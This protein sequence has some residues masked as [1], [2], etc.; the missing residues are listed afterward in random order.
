LHRRHGI[1]VFCEGDFLASVKL[2]DFVS[3]SQR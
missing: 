1:A 3:G 2:A